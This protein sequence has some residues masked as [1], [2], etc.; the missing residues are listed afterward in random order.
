LQRITLPSASSRGRRVAIIVAAVIAGVVILF[1]ALSG[2]FVDL[3]WFREV[4]FSEVF[5]TILRTKFAL[6]VMF[7]A[8]FFALLYANLVI[9]RRLTPKYR[10]VTPEQEIIERYRMAFE[11][12]ARWLIPVFAL[13][14]ATFVGLGVT[15]QWQTFLLWRNSSGVTFGSVDPVFHRDP[16]FYVFTLPW[17]KFVQGWLFSSLIG[18]T[19]LAGLAHY[20]WGGI[21]PQAPGFGD[22]V[23]PQVKAHMSVLLGLVM[24]TKAWGY[25]L[26]QFSLL[27]SRRG[28]VTGASYTD[29]NAQLPA[30]RILLFIALACAILFLVNIRMRGWALPVIAVGLL[31]LVSIT[32]GAAYPAFV[33]RF[34]VAPQELQKERPF[35][36]RNIAATRTAFGLDGII[37]RPESVTSTVTAQDIKANDAT[38][39]NVRLWR[40]DILLNNFKALQ[41]IL[42]FYE[43]SDVDVDRYD[44]NGA[45]RVLMVSAREV[46]QN[47][48]P[49]GGGTWQNRHLVYTHGFGAVASQVNTATTEGQ[50]VFTLQDIPPV[51]QPSLT[52]NGSRVYYG[53]SS[54][55][56]FVVVNTG[57]KELDYQGTATN[58][59]AQVTSTYQGQGGIPIGGFFQR[60]LFAWR[61]K[62]VNLLISG[63]VHGDS[64]IMIYRDITERVPKAAP[65]LK[66]DGDPYAAVVDGQMVWIWDAY[67]TTDQ[68]P[69]SQELTLDDSVV[70]EGKVPLT[71]TVNYIRNSVKVVVNAYD[72]TMTYYVADPTDPIIQVWQKAFP[73]LFT[74][75]ADASPELQAH[76]RFPENL[77]QIQAAQF[78]NYHV[79]DPTVFY[80]KQGFWQIPIDPT[81]GD[82]SSTLAMRPYYL[83]MKLPGDTEESFSLILPFT[84]EGRQNMVAWMAAKSDPGTDYG[85]MLAIE[86][87]PGVNIDGP[88]QVFSRI[89]ADARFSQER[90]LLGQGGSNIQFGDLL[91]IP[92]EQGLL[93]VEPVFVVS[94]QANAIPELK[95]V[96]VVNGG[97]VGIGDTLR[98]ALNDSLGQIVVPPGGGGGQP[99]PGG[100]VQE[101][102]NA[103]IQQAVDHF[104]KADAAL[105]AGDLATYQTEINAAQAA[106]SRANELAAGQSGGGTSPSPSPSASASPSP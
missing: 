76:F 14:I 62:D 10:A 30:L 42:Q 8:A 40:P 17:L 102:I 94:N 77:F 88:T 80:G 81:I 64:R 35:I 66:F 87:P 37:T 46:D 55:V 49:G 86:F 89:N 79:T 90:T 71:G 9:V 28:V 75:L 103:L 99:P 4:G 27:T 93:Y 95:R 59:Q 26:G 74:P 58:D 70:S 96:L 69:Y 25:Y 60:A 106:I 85:K 39:S 53:E 48:I 24:L 63:L 22:K 101:Q 61:F 72:G 83:L 19:L 34:R 23:T 44:L 91:V 16:A 73:D 100:T 15:T 11:P 43:F 31:A 20:L 51:G 18:V 98:D 105:K 12:Y 68:F 3:L 65:F 5:W 50:P 32:A 29:V 56:P 7:G 38:I 33:Q 6:G 47:G 45:R 1:T 41:R 78:A 54:I 67:T 104:A 84:P 2:F 36:E 21:R 57:A 52:D 13:V 97:T 82:T 92:I